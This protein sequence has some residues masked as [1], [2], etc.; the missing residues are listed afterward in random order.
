[1]LAVFRF[2]LL[3]MWL[4]ASVFVVN[5]ESGEGKPTLV[6]V[7][8]ASDLQFAFP[9]LIALYE[10][11]HPGIQI[12][13]TYGS[14]GKFYEQLKNGAPFDLFLSADAAFPRKLIEAGLGAES[15]LF[16]YAIGYLVLW[17]PNSSLDLAGKG[18]ELLRDPKVKKIAIANPE[19]APYGRAAVAA[20]QKLGVY[21][22]VKDKLVLGENVVQAAQFVETGAAEVGLIALSVALARLKARGKYQEVPEEAYPKLEQAGLTLL[23]SPHATRARAFGAWLQ[24]PTARVIWK[25]HGFGAPE[26]PQ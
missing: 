10:K 13:P 22:A 14:S 19:H 15:D 2:F 4:V 8:A 26:Q 16:R 21:D 23:G 9:D 6:L 18:M 24:T 25:Q 7:A 1:M 3:T 12:R 17:T 11:D 5:A 20:M